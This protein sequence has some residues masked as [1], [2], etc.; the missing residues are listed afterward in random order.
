MDAEEAPERGDHD[1]AEDAVHGR[2]G[3]EELVE[4]AAR[5]AW[6]ARARAMP[7]MAACESTRE[8][9]QRRGHGMRSGGAQVPEGVSTWAASRSGASR[10]ARSRMRIRGPP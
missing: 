3:L 4:V 7:T 9:A 2:V 5:G 6:A 1:E 8:G 10:W